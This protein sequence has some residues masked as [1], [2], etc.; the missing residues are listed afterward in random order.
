MAN[1][2]DGGNGVYHYGSSGG[3]PTATHRAINY[4]VDVLVAALAAGTAC[5][6][7]PDAGTPVDA[8]AS[9]DAAPEFDAAPLV[10]AGVSQDAAAP[11]DANNVDA[12][13]DS[14]VTDC[15]ARP[16]LYVRP[17]AS[18]N[19]TD[20][21]NAYGALPSTPTRGATYI[22]AS[23]DYGGYVF[24]AAESGTTRITVKKAT[25]NDH[26]TS[27]GWLDSYATGQ[28]TFGNLVFATGY[29]TLDGAYGSGGDGSSYGMATRMVSGVDTSYVTIQS[30]DI[31]GTVDGTTICHIAVTCQGPIGNIPQTAYD[32]GT[33]TNATNTVMQFVFEDNCR[34]GVH[35]GPGEL[36]ERSYFARAWSSPQ[37]HGE[38][39]DTMDSSNV[40]FRY[41]VVAQCVG[42]TCIGNYSMSNWDIYGNV[43]ANAT[44]GNGVIG[45]ASAEA[46]RN[47]RIYNNTVVNSPTFFL[48]Q[49]NPV[50]AGGGTGSGNVVVDNLFYNSDSSLVQNGAGAITS[51]NNISVSAD[52]FVNLAV[53]DYHLRADTQPGAV[54]GAPYNV[55]PDGKLRGGSGVWDVGA[56]Q[57]GP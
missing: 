46:I 2:S 8:G 56:F 38:V 4:Y 19:G 44:G 14:G 35:V 15:Q 42:T 49:N 48:Y 36:I 21:S 28:A 25:V 51:S 40:T 10:D 54:L 29:W 9:V 23:G 39:V 27:T 55:D 20:W 52:P 7:S 11:G 32:V 26:G 13:L 6:P 3:F 41:N 22:V 37:W 24:N 53:G 30:A 45:A 47:T 50:S 18:G 33:Q 12:S 34:N 57:F 31:D 16:C 17:G 43:F 5:G 1:G